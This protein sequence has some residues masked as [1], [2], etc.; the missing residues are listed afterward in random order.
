MEIFQALYPWVQQVI[1]GLIVTAITTFIHWLFFN[2]KIFKN[3]F[4]NINLPEK[5]IDKELKSVV[6]YSIFLTFF[7]VVNIWIPGVI[8]DTFT[9]I[10]LTMIVVCAIIW[11]LTRYYVLYLRFAHY[12]FKSSKHEFSDFP[13]NKPAD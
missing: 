1:I 5:T 11:F 4:S 7:L 6:F 2:L 8:N 13:P 10:L 12:V 9:K 3:L